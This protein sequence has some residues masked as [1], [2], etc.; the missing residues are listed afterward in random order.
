VHFNFNVA[1]NTTTSLDDIQVWTGSNDTFQYLKCSV[2]FIL[3][4][5]CTSVVVMVKFTSIATGSETL[6]CI[7]R[8]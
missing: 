2:L 3:L 8:K 6:A 1:C 7:Q 5:Q 4:A